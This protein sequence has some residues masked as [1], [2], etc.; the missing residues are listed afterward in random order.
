MSAV[1][2]D[3]FCW[4]CNQL[5]AADLHPPQMNED[6]ER[7]CPGCGSDFVELR[8]PQAQVRA[9]LLSGPNAMSNYVLITTLFCRRVL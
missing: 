2:E 7:M 3:V 4:G 1:T 5:Y 8:G 6:G 9:W